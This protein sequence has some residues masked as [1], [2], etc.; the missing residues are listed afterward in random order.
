MKV[1]FT[2]FVLFLWSCN[3]YTQIIKDPTYFKD[4]GKISSF[5]W[6]PARYQNDFR[7]DIFYYIPESLRE[8]NHVNSL[9]FMH[10]GGGS[11]LTRSGS[12]AAVKLYI[13]DFKKIADALGIIVVLPSTNGLNWGGHTRGILRNLAELMRTNLNINSNKLGLAG[14]S[15]GAM[16]ITRAYP[17]IADEFAFFMPMAA[18][19]DLGMPSSDP[20]ILEKIESY[21][22]KVFNVSYVHLQGKF[23]HFREFVP[24]C[25][26]QVK[27]TKKLELKYRA[28]SKLEMILHQGSHNYDFGLMKNTLKRLYTNV[29][30]NLYQKKLWGLIHTVQSTKTENQ[31][32]SYNY[33]SEA[34][35]FWIE[36]IEPELSIEERINFHASII[37][38]NIDI[39]IIGNMPKQNKKLRIYLH[40]SMVDLKSDSFIFING[41]QVGVRFG[42]T[43]HQEPRN[44]DPKDPS[45]LFEDFIDVE[46]DVENSTNFTFTELQQLAFSLKQ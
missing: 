23:D 44:L 17:W 7:Y 25:E 21:L 16:G 43:E 26:D 18:G 33:D 8:K 20:I 3:S 15:M 42:N 31:N 14:H 13:E 37:N 41:K 45:F 5:S 39:N 30:R 46:I 38:N 40:S 9:I 35:Y 12:I 10:G 22:N 24:R 6:A 1:A 28:P 27:R 11:T 36:A 4:I 2:S 29:T 32:I 19:M 34:R